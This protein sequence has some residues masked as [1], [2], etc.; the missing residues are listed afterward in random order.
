M[1]KKVKI[2]CT[3]SDYEAI[4]AFEWFQGDLKELPEANYQKLKKQIL[5]LG[6]S[7]PI[8][9]WLVEDENKKYILNGHQRILT[10]KRMRDD[11]GYEVPYV[12]YILVEAENHHEAK[13]KVLSLASQF[14][15]ITAKGLKNFISDM[16]LAP[17]D[18]KDD[19]ALRDVDLGA[20]DLE[21]E[22]EPVSENDG[23]E[24]EV[25]EHTRTIGKDTELKDKK[26]HCPECGFTWD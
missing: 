20:L 4:D 5:R 18:L 17:L 3:G 22:L 25:S 8:A 11:E 23:K 24:V 15:V 16:D 2:A 19:F 26:N 12:P 9:A 1:S 6:F 7:E 13:M 21:S 10:L 14:G